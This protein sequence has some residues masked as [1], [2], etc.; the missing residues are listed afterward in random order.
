MPVAAAQRVDE[1]AP[2]EVF[3]KLE[4]SPSAVLID[5]RTRAEWSFVGLPDLG[6]LG[7]E[8]WPIEWQSFPS[9]AQNPDFL[10]EIGTRLQRGVP[11]RLFFICR[12]GA[13]SMAAAEAAQQT[14]AR[15]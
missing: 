11:E 13:R 4:S 1:L 14:R 15:Y 12:S 9:K 5:V 10:A 8:L 6:A 2:L 7:R 3:Q